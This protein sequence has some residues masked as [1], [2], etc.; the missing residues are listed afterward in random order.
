MATV[1][2]KKDWR[3][4]N[5]DGEGGAVNAELILCGIFYKLFIWSTFNN[6]FTI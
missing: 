3:R 5:L 2:E 1:Y 6:C 4:H